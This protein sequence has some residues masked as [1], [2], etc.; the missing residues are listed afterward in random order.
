MCEYLWVL[1]T[2]LSTVFPR[3]VPV[4]TINLSNWNNADTFGAGTI[5]F[6]HVVTPRWQS[7]N[8]CEQQ[9]SWLVSLFP[10]DTYMSFTT[11]TWTSLLHWWSLWASILALLT[12]SPTMWPQLFE[13]ADADTNQGRILFCSAQAI[14]R[15]LIE[16]GYYSTFGYY[17]S[18]Y[19][20][21]TILDVYR[22]HTLHRLH[23]FY[24]VDHFIVVMHFQWSLF[25]SVQTWWSF[26]ACLCSF[27][28]FTAAMLMYSM[29]SMGENQ[30][31]CH[32][33]AIYPLFA[34]VR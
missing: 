11:S 9:W 16:G 22:S 10:P 23:R 17:S 24:T 25:A 13:L 8:A 7:T 31:H 3:I 1:L 4:D 20:I 12:A 2:K 14:M 21:C 30:F 34:Y 27:A 26:C 32:Y 15:I 28:C 18:K 33:A 5:I 19:S 6:M 29:Y